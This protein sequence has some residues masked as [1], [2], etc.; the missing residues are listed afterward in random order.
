[1]LGNLSF[2]ALPEKPYLTKSLCDTQPPLPGVRSTEGATMMQNGNWFGM[3]GGYWL[4][5]VIGVL[6]IVLLVV[7]ITKMS[8]KKS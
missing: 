3:G 1:M 6:V 4:L 8:N 7:V 5:P 2:S